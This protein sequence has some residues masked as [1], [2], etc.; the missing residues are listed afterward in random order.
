VGRVYI[1]G[2]FLIVIAGAATYFL[3]LAKIGQKIFKQKQQKG[4]DE[5]P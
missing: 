5:Q 4:N 2:G 3:F 1:F